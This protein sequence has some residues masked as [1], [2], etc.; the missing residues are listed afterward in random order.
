VVVFL[1]AVDG[2]LEVCDMRK[3]ASAFSAT[4]SLVLE[5]QEKKPY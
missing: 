1:K 3:A 5:Y 4:G 2:F